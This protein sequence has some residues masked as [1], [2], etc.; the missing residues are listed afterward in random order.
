M[1]LKSKE[2][3]RNFL[4][5]YYCTG[6]PFTK[7]RA[8]SDF[9]NV[10]TGKSKK[11]PIGKAY[12]LLEAWFNDFL[13]EGLIELKS[14]IEKGAKETLYTLTPKYLRKLKPEKKVIE[15][16]PRIKIWKK[17][18]KK[19]YPQVN[20]EDLSW[21]EKVSK[22]G[23][24]LRSL[25]DKSVIE[26]SP[27]IVYKHLVKSCRYLVFKINDQWTHINVNE[28][29]KISI[30]DFLDQLSFV[31]N[32]EKIG[33]NTYKLTSKTF[34]RF[35]LISSSEY[36]KKIDT[37]LDVGIFVGSSI[38]FIAS[39]FLIL[40]LAYF[41]PILSLIKALND[42]LSLLMSIWIL[43]FLV[44]ILITRRKKIWDYYIAP[45]LKWIKHKL[46]G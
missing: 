41:V 17:K 23:Y 37:N 35:V 5:E 16:L 12:G 4:K 42:I 40:F 19:K 20:F 7:A 24:I 45:I 14:G 43:S 33:K 15:K 22:L 44:T 26:V 38:M 31:K 8:Y 2:E 6:L 34:E 3:F 27:E 36:D 9:Y 18:G 21:E 10:K 32:I 39:F 11:G 1:I 28:N 25:W 13:K 29:A 30:K 46:S